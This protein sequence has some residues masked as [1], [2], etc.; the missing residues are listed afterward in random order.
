MAS[1]TDISRPHKTLITLAEELWRTGSIFR[2]DRHT[3]RCA[4][5]SAAEALDTTGSNGVPLITADFGIR[6]RGST[7]PERL[8]VAPSFRHL[9][10]MFLAG[11]ALALQ[12]ASESDGPDHPTA[13]NRLIEGAHTC[14]R[15]EIILEL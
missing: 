1:S 4:R 10:A 12:L 8:N 7:V 2:L 11:I 9:A 14:A 5:A 13:P 6:P 15:D 3:W